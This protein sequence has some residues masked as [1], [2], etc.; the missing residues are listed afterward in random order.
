M[1]HNQPP[2]CFHYPDPIPRDIAAHGVP[3][4]PLER[5][6]SHLP[7]FEPQGPYL[8]HTH[9]AGDNGAAKRSVH[10]SPGID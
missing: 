8:T 5:E 2:F 10:A 6:P 7:P 3:V 1:S 9:S 4:G